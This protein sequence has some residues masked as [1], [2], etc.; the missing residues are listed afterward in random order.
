MSHLIPL[1]FLQLLWISPS[2]TR[3]SNQDG[4]CP[5]L[6][7]LH[8]RQ[9]TSSTQE[10]FTETIVQ[11]VSDDKYISQTHG[12]EFLTRSSSKINQI[13]YSE[14]MSLSA[15]IKTLWDVNNKCHQKPYHQKLLLCLNYFSLPWE[16]KKNRLK[17]FICHICI[18]DCIT[19]YNDSK[20]NFQK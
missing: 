7:N 20:W 3:R 10:L 1:P 17:I 18:D 6:I 9:W 2:L 8:M 16:E 5:L 15:L 12:G 14:W 19:R 4:S 13:N 11:T